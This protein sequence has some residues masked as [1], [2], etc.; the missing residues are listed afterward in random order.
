MVQ[1]ADGGALGMPPLRGFPGTSHLEATG[2]HDDE[3]PGVWVSHRPQTSRLHVHP[4]IF[5]TSLRLCMKRVEA[6]RLRSHSQCKV[7]ESGINARGG[8]GEGGQCFCS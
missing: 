2:S 4:G 8:A 1:A 5:L 3:P 7:I 6:Q